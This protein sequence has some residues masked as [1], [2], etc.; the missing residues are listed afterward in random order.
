MGSPRLAPTAHLS[1]QRG[2]QAAVERQDAVGAH[3]P[4]CHARHAQLH[5]LLRLQMHLWERVFSDLTATPRDR[6]QVHPERRKVRQETVIRPPTALPRD[7]T[8]PLGTSSHHCFPTATTSADMEPEA[9]ELRVPVSPAGARTAPE[10]WLHWPQGLAILL[11][12]MRK[13]R[14]GAVTHSLA[15]SGFGPSEE[16]PEPSFLSTTPCLKRDKRLRG[17]RNGQGACRTMGD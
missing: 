10:S 5:L 16:T 14:H 13:L 12:Q 11:L 2:A 3:H 15:P 7:S 4:Q 6:C 1:A 8:P 9:M 17:L